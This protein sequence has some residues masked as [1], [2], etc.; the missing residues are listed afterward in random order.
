MEET[1]ATSQGFWALLVN[2]IIALAVSLMSSCFGPSQPETMT[3]SFGAYR[4]SPV[5]LLDAR[6][7]GKPVAVP[8][9][10]VDGVADDPMYSPRAGGSYSLLGYPRSTGHSEMIVSMTWVEVFTQKAWTAEVRVP[11]DRFD[12][13][14]V[15]SVIRFAPIFGPNGLM[16]VSSDPIPTSATNIPRVD[17]ARICGSRVPGLDRDYTAKPDETISM[18]DLL[19]T[20]RVPV[21]LPE[22]AGTAG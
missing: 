1:A 10:L 8:G 21:V 6:V 17:V 13:N 4:A 15:R 18:A 3:I 9:S 19:T 12:G 2:G 5:I 16:I 14:R 20:E 22:C 7:N 11:L